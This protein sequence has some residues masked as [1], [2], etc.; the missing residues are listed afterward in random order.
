MISLEFV[1]FLQFHCCVNESWQ[2][3]IIFRQLTC[4]AALLALDE[5]IYTY[6]HMYIFSLLRKDKFAGQF[7]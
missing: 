5:K 1:A 6:F 7:F 2:S 4:V 3:L